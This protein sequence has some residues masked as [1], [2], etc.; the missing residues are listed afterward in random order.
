MA[1]SQG[2]SVVVVVMVTLLAFVV[3]GGIGAAAIYFT[4][5][6]NP[7][8]AGLPTT[9]TA[10][11]TDCP[12]CEDAPVAAVGTAANY[13]LVYPIEESL[14]VTGTLSPDVIK[15]QVKSRRYTFSKC[16]Q[17]ALDKDPSLKGEM[18]IQFTVSGSSG[19][20][21]AA[22]ERDTKIDRRIHD[23][24]FAEIKKWKFEP[25]KAAD[26]VARFDMLFVPIGG[27]PVE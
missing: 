17:D 12:P 20:I 4:L 16:Y 10:V 6:A 9:T 21:I 11:A 25:T 24:V 26:S 23:C 22:I 7:S 2:C 14:R 5:S 3:G 8:L 1:E 13:A 19:R 27:A 15:D 18:S